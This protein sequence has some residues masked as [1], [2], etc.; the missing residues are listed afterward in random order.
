MKVP[1]LQILTERDM[2]NDKRAVPIQEIPAR[3]IALKR[4]AF[5]VR[6]VQFEIRILLW[7]RT[8]H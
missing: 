2:L 7:Q 3:S 1:R 8:L 6:K 4:F 5:L